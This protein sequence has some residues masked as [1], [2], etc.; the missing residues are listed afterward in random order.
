MVGIAAKMAEDHTTTARCVK[1]SMLFAAAA[2]A[3]GFASQPAAAAGFSPNEGFTAD[4]AYQW[5]I[6]L[7]PAGF[8]PHIEAT[9]NGLGP[10][11]QVGA[12]GSASAWKLLSVLQGAFFGVGVVRY[13]P[14]SAEMNIDYVE[15]GKSESTYAPRLG[16]EVGVNANYTMVLVS[17]GIGYEAYRGEVASVP[18]SL[19]VRAGFQYLYSDPSLTTDR[20]LLGGAGTSSEYVAPWIGLRASVYPTDHWRVSLLG[21]LGGLGINDGSVN[22]K[23]TL[24]ASYLITDWAYVDFGIAAI[25]LNQIH[26]DTTVINRQTQQSLHAIGYGPVLGVGFRF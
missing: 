1:G 21:N 22:W 4:G 9:A 25:G 5:H 8:A 23:T 24:L 12:D 20:N 3:V 14:Y 6:D 26:K 18:A 11:G 7:N 15:V 19:D 16:R 13:G 17:P 10:R 2:L